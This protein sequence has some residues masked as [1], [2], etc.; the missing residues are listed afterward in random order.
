MD[1][2]AVVFG[3]AS[4]VIGGMAVAGLNRWLPGYSI[5]ARTWMGI[6][7]ALTPEFLLVAIA[8][9]P[10]SGVVLLSMSP[11]EFLV[12]FTVQILLTLAIAAP[13]A[14]LVA[15]RVAVGT[16]SVDVFD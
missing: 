1:V 8:I 4:G 11:D 10:S 5:R 7:V 14:W 15:R 6:A 9:L 12:P 13:M 16:A 2:G 3:V